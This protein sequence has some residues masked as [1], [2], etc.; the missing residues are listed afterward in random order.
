MF[1]PLHLRLYNIIK[2]F[3]QLFISLGKVSAQQGWHDIYQ[4][5]ISM[6]FATKI[7]YLICILFFTHENF[8]SPVN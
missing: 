7:S 2:Y 1:F 5:F 6:I 4:R 3:R 8:G